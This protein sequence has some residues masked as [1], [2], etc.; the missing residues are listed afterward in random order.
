VYLEIRCV[1]TPVTYWTLTLSG[2]GTA[3]L[4]GTSLIVISLLPI[5]GN[6]YVDDERAAGGW[7]FKQIGR[8]MSVG[9]TTRT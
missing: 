1:A 9:V 7:I 3:T 2:S 4:A 6:G 5:A 8:S